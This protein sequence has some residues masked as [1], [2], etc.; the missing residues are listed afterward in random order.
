MIARIISGSVAMAYFFAAWYAGGPGLAVKVAGFLLFCLGCIWFSEEVGSY[1]GSGL[2]GRSAI[3]N[4]S[5]GCMVAAGGWMLL[6]L[7]ALQFLIA[8]F[9]D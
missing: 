7:P 9:A 2:F 4:S 1:T 6:M 3:T 8:I 5:P